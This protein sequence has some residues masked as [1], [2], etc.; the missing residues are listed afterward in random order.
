MEGV[1][2]KKMKINGNQLE[3]WI[4]NNNIST[5]MFALV[6]GP[7]AG[8][9]DIN[10][11]RIAKAFDTTGNSSVTKFDFKDIKDDF[12]SLVDEL[13][14]VSLF[15][16]TKIVML[17]DCPQ[18]LPKK[19]LEFLEKA[20][21]AGKLI[22]KSGEL[23]P[24]SN[25]RK[26]SENSTS[27]LSVASYKD[28]VRQIEIYVRSFLQERGAKSDAAVV[29]VLA[30]ILPPN[31]LLVACELEKLITYKFG[32]QITLKDVED[33]ISDSQEIGLDDLCVSVALGQKPQINKLIERAINTD[34]SFMLIL[35]VLQR[36]FVRVLDVLAYMEAGMGVDMA[37][38]KLAPPVF[39]KQRDNLIRVCRLASKQKILTLTADL[40][41]LEL[42]C[43]RLP[44][45]QYMLIT[46][47]LNSRVV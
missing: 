30:Q 41:K 43:K 45:D 4:K 14:S 44:M 24:T 42:D 31:K 40:V 3:T 9:V 18:S 20:S 35:R 21:F 15:G 36:Y 37:V 16:D 6:Y 25:L 5:V 29:S 10:A 22:L 23:R 27:A 17:E 46:N 26:L 1:R 47:Y 39:F 32:E 8:G 13:S 12:S 28:D 19:M 7:D 34:I 38:G 2:I 33:V 11:A